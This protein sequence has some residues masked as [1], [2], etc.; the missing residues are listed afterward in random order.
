[1]SLIDP[2]PGIKW[3]DNIALNR[4]TWSHIESPLAFIMS[5][6]CWY[7]FQS[8]VWPKTSCQG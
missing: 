1:L 4:A 7:H 3:S 5:Q 8:S 2:K 6:T